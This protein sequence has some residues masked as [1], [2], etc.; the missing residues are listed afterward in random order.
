VMA[1][2]GKDL[3]LAAATAAVL[4]ACVLGAQFILYGLAPAYYAVET[5]GT[6]T[7]ATV[8]A[9]RLGSA[10]GP[11]F[12]GILLGHGASGTHVLQALLPVT[13]LAAAAAIGL[14]FLRRAPG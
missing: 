11:F 2:L 7:G 6:G 3:L 13:A 14:L 12:A 9:S 5:R 4:G 8:A 1:P 10:V